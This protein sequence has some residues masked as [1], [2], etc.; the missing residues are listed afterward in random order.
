MSKRDQPDGVKAL[1]LDFQ[2]PTQRISSDE[3]DNASS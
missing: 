3:E 2:V 1:Q